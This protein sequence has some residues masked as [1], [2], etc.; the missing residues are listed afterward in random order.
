MQLHTHAQSCL[1]LCDP[2]TIA[3][4]APLSMGFSRQEY[5]SGLPFPPQGDLPNPMIRPKSPASPSLAGGF[6]TTVPPGKPSKMYKEHFF[7]FPGGLFEKV[8]KEKG[9]VWKTDIILLKITVHKILFLINLLYFF[10][11]KMC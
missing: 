7:F 6:F 10:L 9:E 11:N 5:W 4:R 3:G 2:W 1:T 8:R